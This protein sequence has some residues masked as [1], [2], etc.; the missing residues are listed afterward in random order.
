MQSA[1]SSTSDR[2]FSPTTR[3]PATSRTLP[4]TVARASISLGARHNS[5]T[6][7][8]QEV[9]RLLTTLSHLSRRLR[10][11]QSNFTTVRPQRMAHLRTTVVLEVPSTLTVAFFSSITRR[12]LT[13]FSSTMAALG[14]RAPL[15]S[16]G[17]PW[18]A[19]PL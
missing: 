14:P 2:Y 11:A 5:L 8:L 1:S 4:I 10:V 3:P 16:L 7:H 9:A 13:V 6:A 17:E 12:R 15:Y 19:V 18:T